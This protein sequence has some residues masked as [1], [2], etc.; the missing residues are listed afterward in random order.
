MQKVRRHTLACAPTAC[1]HTV[2]GSISLPSPGFFSPFP[3]GTS[4]LS[5]IEEYLALADGPAGFPPGFTC[6]VV[7]GVLATLVCVSLTGLSPSVDGE[8]HPF[9][10]HVSELV[11]APQPQKVCTLWFRLF[12]FRSPLLTE[13]L[14][15]FLFLWVLRWFNS[16][17]SPV[18]AMY[19]RTH[20]SFEGGCPIQTSP[21]QSLLDSSP[22]LFAAYHVFRRF[23]MP[24]HPPYALI[25][26]TLFLSLH[27]SAHTICASL[28]KRLHAQFEKHISFTEFRV[29]SSL[30]SCQKT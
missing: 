18:D 13:S 28:H 2:S 23:S 9:K 10:L 24:R 27:H 17:R 7:L 8:F 16:P 15:C 21:D 12:R 26:L 19:S 5:V 20:P 14:F 11:P 30:F 3:H 1:K 4:S 29:F 25:M 22:R 6:P